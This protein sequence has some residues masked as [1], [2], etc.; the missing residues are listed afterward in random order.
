VLDRLFAK[1]GDAVGFH[2]CPPPDAA[3]GDEVLANKTLELATD[4]IS[5]ARL[6][7]GV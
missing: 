4:R 2:P 6:I 1:D 5:R 3:D 7:S